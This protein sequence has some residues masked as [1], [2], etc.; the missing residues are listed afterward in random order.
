MKNLV[1]VC[2]Y[3]IIPRGLCPWDS[4]NKVVLTISN[5]QKVTGNKFESAENENELLLETSFLDFILTAI[6]SWET[7][8]DIDR[9]Q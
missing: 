1:I 4:W 5:E 6:T 3:T 7:K 8:Y 2:S 9:Q